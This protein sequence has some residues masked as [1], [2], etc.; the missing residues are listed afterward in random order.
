GAAEQAAVAAA[1][2]AQQGPRPAVHG[3]AAPV[4]AAE[5]GFRLP[6]EVAVAEEGGGPQSAGEQP[7]GVDGAGG[8]AAPG[9]EAT[10]LDEVGE[11]AAVAGRLV[12]GGGEG[13]ADARSRFGGVEQAVRAGGGHGEGDQAHARGR[14]AAQPAAPPAEVTLPVEHQAARELVVEE[15]AQRLG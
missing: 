7:G 8:I 11:D 13:A 1:A 12:A 9:P 5:Q 3:P 6:G 15:V 2:V 10:W 4:D 14:G